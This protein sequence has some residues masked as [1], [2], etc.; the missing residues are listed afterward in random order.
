[1]AE[2]IVATGRGRAW[3]DS[4]PPSIDYVL[5]TLVNVWN[6]M[7]TKVSNSCQI[8]MYVDQPFDRD[9]DNTI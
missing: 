5:S 4:T 6:S 7:K 9:R 8:H 3:H 1:M 2:P